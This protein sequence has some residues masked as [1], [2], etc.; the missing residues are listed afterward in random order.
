MSIMFP[1]MTMSVLLMAQLI[2]HWLQYTIRIHLL[3]IWTFVPMENEESYMRAM[4]QLAEKGELAVNL[5]KGMDFATALWT[6]QY[7]PSMLGARSQK[8]AVQKVINDHSFQILQKPGEMV[9]TLPVRCLLEIEDHE[10]A[11]W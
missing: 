1:Y 11:T 5:P 3:Q 7:Y 8:R 2:C 6:K 10:T 4:E 9:V